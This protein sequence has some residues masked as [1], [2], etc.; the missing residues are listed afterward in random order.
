MFIM[1]IF[2]PLLILTVIGILQC[3]IIISIVLKA[4]VSS[5][6]VQILSILVIL[7]FML[8]LISQ[9][10]IIQS[11]DEKFQITNNQL[12]QLI[13][14]VYDL[15]WICG[16]VFLYLLFVRNIQHTFQNTLYRAAASTL[17][18]LYFQ[19]VI[20]SLVLLSYYVVYV[21]Y[22]RRYI[23]HEAF[24]WTAFIII[25]AGEL[26]EFMLSIILSY[27][28][29]SRLVK[30]Y[31]V[32]N[33]EM[34]GK[35]QNSILFA[36]FRYSM[37][38]FISIISTQLFYI[39]LG[40]KALGYSNSFKY[41]KWSTI[42]HLHLFSIDCVIN[43]FCVYMNLEK[44]TLI[45]RLCAQCCLK[46]KNVKVISINNQHNIVDTDVTA[47]LLQE[48]STKTIHNQTNILSLPNEGLTYTNST[49]DETISI[50]GNIHVTN[51]Y[52]KAHPN[53]LEINVA[54][55]DGHLHVTDL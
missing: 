7:S 16:H 38:S 33:I 2:Y 22:D 50:M 47:V 30:L 12:T 32:S 5:N 49:K 46:N 14:S 44:N 43:S 45:I 4:K 17:I 9:I 34:Q 13:V 36:A 31:K 3:I 8:G 19:I 18:F 29:I 26:N 39:S 42:V 28:F 41:Y 24:S 35:H 55:I 20:F 52:N 37:I 15:T 53:E 40:N 23:S 51:K 1:Y 21:M 11:L 10:Y 54:S 6:I 27:M 48:S 25:S